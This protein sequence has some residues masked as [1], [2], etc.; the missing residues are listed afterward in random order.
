MMQVI[1]ELTV[2]ILIAGTA[3]CGLFR[4]VDVFSVFVRGARRGIGVVLRIL[5]SL[6]AL[7]TAVYM[8]RV[9]GLTDALTALLSPVLSLLGIP[10]ET[11]PLMLIRPISGSGALA[12]A[13][14]MISEYGVDS[15]I[16]TTA[17]VMLGS[18]ETTF[19]TISVYF[20][21]LGIKNTRYAIPAALCADLAGFAAASFFT[22][23]FFG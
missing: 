18:T 14:D 8:L 9:S 22:R 5:P 10:K 12:A 7:L 13:S 17:A 19:Y 23:L 2:P 6:A 4:N 15:L 1:S 21:S 20:G 11:A 3:L 16:G